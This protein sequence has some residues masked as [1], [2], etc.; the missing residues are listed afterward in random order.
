MNYISSFVLVFIRAAILV[1]FLN[2]VVVVIFF[3]IAV[4]LLLILSLGFINY[5]IYFKL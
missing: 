3:F 1:L 2:T 5:L 4:V